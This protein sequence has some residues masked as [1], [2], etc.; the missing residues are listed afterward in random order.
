MPLPCPS[1]GLSTPR[2]SCSARRRALSRS[3]PVRVLAVRNR[4][5]L[6]DPDDTPLRDG[7]RDRLFGLLTS[8]AVATLLTYSL[9]TNQN[10]G[11]WLNN[12]LSTV[13]GAGRW[14]ATSAPCEWRQGGS[15]RAWRGWLLVTHLLTPWLSTP[16]R[17]PGRGLKYQG[18]TS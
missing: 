3:G 17:A 8:R 11:Q 9:E 14:R 2:P 15:W 7:N 13:S 10:Q 18:T 4:G 1:R 12:Y 16:S 6:R 5:R